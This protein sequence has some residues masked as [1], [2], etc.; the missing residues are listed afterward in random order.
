[1]P[2]RD[3][4]RVVMGHGAGGKL[5]AELVEHLFLPAFGNDDQGAN[6]ADAAVLS[7]GAER[8]AFSTDSF[9]VN[10]LF[11]PGGNIGELAVNG[12]VNDLAMMGARP[13]Y[14]SCGFILEEGFP[15]DQLGRIA[16]AL[17]QAAKQAGVRMVTGDTKVV[18]RGRGHG[19][20]I[21]TS[22]LG[23][24]PS[25]FELG[26]ERARPGD[27][28]L[29][30]GPIGNHGMAV[31]SV[32]EGLEF[33]TA[34][35]SDTASLYSLVELLMQRPE[36]FRAFR[37]PTRGGLA[38]ALN[39]LAVASRVGIVVEETNVPVDPAVRA[40]CE[41]LGLDPMCVA[42]EGKMLAVVDQQAAEWAV[43]QLRSHPL[44]AGAAVI[45]AVTE[46]NP[47]LV[48]VKTAFGAH[49]VLD[50]QLGE[51]LPRIC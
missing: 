3:H 51:Q 28:V 4:P 49:R 35:R 30:S 25:G 33:E 41:L 5:S 45:G 6:M 18:E 16:E 1:L 47:G 48:A 9:V 26:P 7:V 32:R 34:I 10:P 36:K 27:A 19:V 2:L 44:G 17:G 14:L 11:F 21:N 24:I 39:E 37:D 42:N 15:T 40:A 43:E 38:S 13:L 8:V 31:M 23:L 22:G 12:T 20:Y 50:M 46:Q 29:V